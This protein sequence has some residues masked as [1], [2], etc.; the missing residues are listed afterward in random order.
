[1]DKDKLTYNEALTI[2]NY[3]KEEKKYYCL[4][5][6]INEIKLIKWKII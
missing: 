2:F 4:K 3:Q 5:K 6:Y 1:M